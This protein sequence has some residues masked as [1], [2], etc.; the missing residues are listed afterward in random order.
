ME[1]KE[2]YEG[3]AHLIAPDEGRVLLPLLAPLVEGLGYELVRV[4]LMGAG[5]RTLQVMAT[6]PDGTMNLEGCEEISHALSALLD[7]E[8]PI[9]GDYRLEVSSPGIAR[10][11]TR[12]QDFLSCQGEKAKLELKQDVGGRKR[13]S[14]ILQG[15]EAGAVRL[16]TTDD[17]FTFNLTNIATA[18]LQGE[19]L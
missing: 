18:K 16:Q 3:Y 13:F 17:I 11:L 9:E 19:P 15:F 1:A 6:R 14:G 12:P 5:T 7:A 10:P 2:T 4:R 8:D